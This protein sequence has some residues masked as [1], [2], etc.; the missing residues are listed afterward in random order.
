MAGHTVTGFPIGR[1]RRV[2]LTSTSAAAVEYLGGIGMA[3]IH[4]REQ[5]LTAYAL[6]LLSAI[7]GLVIYGPPASERGGTSC[8]RSSAG[9]LV[10]ARIPR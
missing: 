9:A 4:E 3:A 2:M 6:D 1:S 8:G 5:A 7:D 10:K